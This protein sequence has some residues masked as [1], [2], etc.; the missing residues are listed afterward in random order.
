[1]GS[2]GCPAGLAVGILDKGRVGHK[3]EFGQDACGVWVQGELQIHAFGG[4]RVGGVIGQVNCIGCRVTHQKAFVW[5][6]IIQGTLSPETRN[7]Q[8]N[9][10]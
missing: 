1:L 4:P 3:A 7:L 6:H 2:A 10:R 5:S 8:G 9:M